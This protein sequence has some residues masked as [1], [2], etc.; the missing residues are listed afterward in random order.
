M[1]LRRWLT[2]QPLALVAD[3]GYAILTCCTAASPCVSRPPSWPDSAWTLPF[4]RQRHHAW[5]V[6]TAARR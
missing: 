6:K 1:Q 5:Q 2:H 3:N 4:M